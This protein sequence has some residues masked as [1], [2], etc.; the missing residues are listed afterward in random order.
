[1]HRMVSN[2]LLGRRLPIGDGKPVSYRHVPPAPL[3]PLIGRAPE[4]A[5]LSLLLAGERVVTLTGS[6]GCGKTRLA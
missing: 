6:G 4:L 3:T 1:M 2:A 5:E